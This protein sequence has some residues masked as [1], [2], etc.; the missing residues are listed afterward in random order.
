MKK[1]AAIIL[2]VGLLGCNNGDPV[3]ALVKNDNIS[4]TTV[5]ELPIRLTTEVAD[6]KF[7]NMQFSTITSDNYNGEYIEFLD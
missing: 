2:L 1:L 6:T 5:G 4:D 7:S 3:P